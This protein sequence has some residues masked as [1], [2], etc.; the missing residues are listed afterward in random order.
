MEIALLHLQVAKDFYF[1]EELRF[2]RCPAM[3]TV[4]IT[5]FGSFEY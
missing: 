4:N 1:E 2:F 5:W 3:E